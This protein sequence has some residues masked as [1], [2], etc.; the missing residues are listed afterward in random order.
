MSLYDIISM[1]L[2]I[3][4]TQYLT[5]QLTLVACQIHWLP[6]SSA[7][8]CYSCHRDDRGRI[9]LAHQTD[10]V[11]ILCLQMR[12]RWNS[13]LWTLCELT[14]EQTQQTLFCGQTSPSHVNRRRVLC[15][16][17]CV[18]VCACVCVCV[19]MCACVYACVCVCVCSSGQRQRDTAVCGS[20]GVRLLW[21]ST[22]INH[23]SYLGANLR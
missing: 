18:H 2:A 10:N 4:A 5:L 19:G 9:F 15:M 21:Y 6:F 17:M 13:P 11:G 7:V 12:L 3:M 20:W 22:T 14:D 1:I 16:C 23:C 8:K